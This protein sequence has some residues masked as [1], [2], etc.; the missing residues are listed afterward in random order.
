MANIA[1]SREL[2]LIIN[3]N[4][5]LSAGFQGQEVNT[6]GDP[7]LAARVNKLFP[8]APAFYTVTF[9]Q[10]GKRLTAAIDGTAQNVSADQL[11]KA[12]GKSAALFN[13]QP[14]QAPAARLTFGTIHQGEIDGSVE[15]RKLAKTACTIIATQFLQTYLIQGAPKT[16]KFVDE[17]IIAGREMYFKLSTPSEEILQMREGF[18]KQIEALSTRKAELEA[19][20]KTSDG[21]TS[22]NKKELE[23]VKDELRFNEEMLGQFK[24]QLLSFDQLSLPDTFPLIKKAGGTSVIKT[25]RN[26]STPFTSALQKLQGIKLP[27]VGAIVTGQGKT[28]AVGMEKNP[29]GSIK[30]ITILNSHDDHDHVGKSSGYMASFTTIEGAARFLSELCPYKSFGDDFKT[31]LTKEEM[32]LMQADY[33]ETHNV[34]LFIP[35]SPTSLE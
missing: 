22:Q 23:T 8:N 30:E 16:A 26:D 12:L 2:T 11:I 1:Q 18:L 9:T 28:Y 25:A 19:L 4:E 14:Q 21:N 27:K 33:D 31:D 29:N 6:S 17:S 5:L 35:I 7:T 24:S 3:Q 10:S 34:A 20:L 13:A 32:A 15:Q